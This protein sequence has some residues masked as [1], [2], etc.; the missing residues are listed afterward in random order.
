MDTASAFPQAAEQ[1][2]KGYWSRPGGKFGILAALG[3]LGW[4]G[5]KL[6]PILTAIV[7]NTVNFGIALGCLAFF[8]FLVT[9]R[10][11]RLSAF[12][13]WE[14]LMRKL[15]GIVIELDPF[16]I[17]DDDIK[18]MVA[19]RQKLLEQ[20][21]NVEA[22]KEAIK[23]KM[24][25]KERESQHLQAKGIA[26]KKNNMLPELGNIT[27]QIERLKQYVQQLAPIYANLSRISEYLT[28]VYKNSGLMIDDAKNELDLKKDLYKSVTAG[29]RALNSALKIFQGD[30]EKKLMVQQ[31]MEYL[32]DDIAAKL[33]NMKQAIMASSDYMKSID[34]DN[35]TFEEEG[36]KMLEKFDP[37]KDFQL[38]SA[39]VQQA[40]TPVKQELGKINA[41]AYDNL[42]Q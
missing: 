18:D 6:L 35:A 8:L 3:L 2:L 29:N 27:R 9:N 39:T 16:V 33:A 28:K 10:K 31:S 15:V 23:A 20:T 11:L 24:D 37:D 14:I 38:T 13:L 34:L 30:P 42:L 21:T 19:Q 26:A 22:Q 17:A 7:W 1:K 32:K 4:A 36:M 25:E 40:T 12:Y 41:T 5:W